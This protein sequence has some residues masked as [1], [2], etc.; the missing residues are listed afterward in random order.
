MNE[1]LTN[2]F[3][4]EHCDVPQGQSLAEWRTTRVSPPPRRPQATTGMFVALAAHLLPSRGS[5]TR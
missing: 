2:S 5:R 3:A 1:Q 4:Y